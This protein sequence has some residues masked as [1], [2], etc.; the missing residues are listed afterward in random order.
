VAR[1]LAEILRAVDD[2]AFAAKV[3]DTVGNALSVDVL[4]GAGAKV[5]LLLHAVGV[6]DAVFKHFAR[7]LTKLGMLLVI[8]LEE[9]LPRALDNG[10][11]SWCNTFIIV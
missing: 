2:V 3:V 4:L 7:L 9:L 11:H 10:G 8:R 5:F 6:L 1:V